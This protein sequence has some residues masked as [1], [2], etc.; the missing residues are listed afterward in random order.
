MAAMRE[1]ELPAPV[2]M[3]PNPEYGAENS[4]NATAIENY[5]QV[6]LQNTD[7]H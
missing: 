1:P 2:G 4:E 6:Y 5:V 7:G 3:A